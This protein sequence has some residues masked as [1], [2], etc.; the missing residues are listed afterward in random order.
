MDDQGHGMQAGAAQ[1]RRVAILDAA[2]ACFARTG[3]HRTTMQDIAGE[4]GMS[5]GNLYRYFANK[6]AVIIALGERDRMEVAQDFRQLEAVDDFVACFRAIGEKHLRDAPPTRT[7]IC[8]EIWAEATRNAVFA[9]I[10]RAFELEM[11]GG[12][13]R[14]FG[15]AQA[16]GAI[17]SKAHPRA[18]A[19][20]VGTIAD[21]LFV[22]RAVSQTFDPSS[23]IERALA[24]IGAVLHGAIDGAAGAPHVPVTDTNS[25]EPSAAAPTPGT[26]S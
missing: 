17:R 22:R 20:T 23:E 11:L 8:L 14:A 16:R 25:T 2:E 26:V 18:L 3:F 13:E 4:A 6:D 21:G 7:A 19:V 24:L 1:D 5:V 15:L 9:E 10:T 12:L